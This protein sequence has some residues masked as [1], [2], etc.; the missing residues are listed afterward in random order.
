MGINEQVARKVRKAIHM[1]TGL[2]VDAVAWVRRETNT[3]FAALVYRSEHDYETALEFLTNP[4]TSG[5]FNVTRET[6]TRIFI[7]YVPPTV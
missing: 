4:R 2:Q 6:A 1:I 3:E 7:E 5:G